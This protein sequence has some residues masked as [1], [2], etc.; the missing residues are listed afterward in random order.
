M[1]LR[2]VLALGA[3]ML[4]FGCAQTQESGPVAPPQQAA[5]PVDVETYPAALFHQTTSYSLGAPSGY[6]FSAQDG[7]I[8]ASTDES[9]IFN[10][11]T[12]D[13]TGA[14]T[15]LTQSNDDA[16]YAQSFFPNDDRILLTSDGGGDE[17]FH[18]YVREEDGTLRAIEV[19]TGQSDGR[20][21]VVRSADLKPGMEV[22]TGVRAQGE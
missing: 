11:V 22:V 21:T 8:L 18:V 7:D 9:G 19:V 15:Q 10:A 14:V 6:V 16:I 5:P 2:T 1:T 4:A 12:L 3:S 13:E 20:R 17:I